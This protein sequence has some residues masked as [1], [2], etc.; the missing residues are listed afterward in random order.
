ME[1]RHEHSTA[2]HITKTLSGDKETET[3]SFVSNH[4]HHHRRPFEYLCVFV[5]KL[6]ADGRIN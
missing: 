4:H 2:Q 5:L 3:T 1:H 6:N